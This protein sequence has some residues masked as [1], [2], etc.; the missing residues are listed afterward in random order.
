[1]ARDPIVN[2][3]AFTTRLKRKEKLPAVWLSVS[4]QFLTEVESGLEI[5]KKE[6]E[7][8][9]DFRLLTAGYLH[10]KVGRK[11]QNTTQ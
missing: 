8:G 7:N 11:R 4:V 3:L 9:V 2:T 5:L 1:M 10:R 6:T